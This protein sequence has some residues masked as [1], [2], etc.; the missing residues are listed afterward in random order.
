MP[1]FADRVSEDDRWNVLNY[2]QSRYGIEAQ[3]ADGDG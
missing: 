2:L 1:A 3:G